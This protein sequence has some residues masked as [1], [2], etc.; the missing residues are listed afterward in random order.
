L[1]K[2]GE[3]GR[4][5]INQYMSWMT[6]PLAALQAYGTGVLLKSQSILTD[7]GCGGPSTL[8]TVAII[9]SMTAGTMLLVWIGELITQYGVGNGVSIIIFGGIMARLPFQVFQGF[10]AGADFGALLMFA[11]LAIITVVAI[12][13]IY[14]GQRRIPVQ[15]SKQI[16]G[17]RVYGGGTT[18][19]PL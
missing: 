4:R 18:H 7:F 9:I 6:V 14:E 10:A 13:Y 17:N 19:I 15:I 5:V 8:S 2:E 1:S 3:S 11:V 16:R 12:I